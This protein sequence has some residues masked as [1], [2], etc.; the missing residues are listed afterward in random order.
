MISETLNL[1]NNGAV[2]LPKEWRERYDTKHFIAK[3]NK[4]GYLVIMPIID[5]EYYERDDGTC[6]LIFPHGIEAGEL[7]KMFKQAE[8]NIEAEEKM[9]KRKKK[10][11]R[12]T[13]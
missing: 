10:P 2:T 9:K 3:E 12:R 13:K 6:G 11:T 5:V 1:W 8:K 7:L 4:Q